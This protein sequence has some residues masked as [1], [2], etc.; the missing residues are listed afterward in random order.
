MNIFVTGA[1]GQL[2]RSIEKIAEEY[3]RHE[4]F[5]TGRADADITDRAKLEMI[6]KD[7]DIDGVINCAAYTAVDRA[8][9]ERIEAFRINGDGVGILAR[10]CAE[11]EAR[12]VHVSTDYV[13][14]GDK[15]GRIT[16]EEVPH[17]LSVYGESKLEGEREVSRSE[18]VSAIVRVQWLY[19]EFGRNFALTMLKAAAEGYGLKI[20]GDQFGTPTYA[21]D[22][23]RALIAV[24]EGGCRKGGEIYNY[25]PEGETSWYGFAR[26]IFRHARIAADVQ[27]VSSDE[28]SAKAVR[29]RCTL[30]DSTKI[31]RELGVARRSW[32]DGIAD[33]LRA[34]RAESKNGGIFS[35]NSK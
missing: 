18:A 2:G 21:V 5:F 28:H 27:C 16:E 8:E 14:A 23:A 30:L 32:Q 35:H 7:G 34:V 15:E 9:D 19:S 4:F 25:S 10:L 11:Y 17:P 20:V 12:L 33:M 1:G 31:V 13:Y 24:L 26:E 29:P 22:A 6:F 3:P